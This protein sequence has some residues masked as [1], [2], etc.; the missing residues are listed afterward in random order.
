[1]LKKVDTKM[2]LS[3]SL[4]EISRCKPVEKITVTDITRNCSLSRESFYYHFKDKY[5]LISWMFTSPY[6]EI[7]KMFDKGKNT[8]E[9]SLVLFLAHL[10]KHFEFFNNALMDDNT[11]SFF[12]SFF[13]YTV[14]AMGNSVKIR[15]SQT[16]CEDIRFQIRFYAHG[17]IGMA[18]E[19]LN[20]KALENTEEIARKIAESMSPLMR[21]MFP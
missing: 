16:A 21:N 20:H 4:L 7:M 10:K 5:D 1:M 8:W 11:N 2:L 13:S 19:W 14:N 15:H 17:A 18:T 3:E 12:E 9:G 6:D